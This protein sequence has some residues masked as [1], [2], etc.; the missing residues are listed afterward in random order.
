M[1]I[2]LTEVLDGSGAIVASG[3]TFAT[4]AYADARFEGRANVATW[5]AASDDTQKRAMLD[6][7]ELLQGKQWIGRLFIDTQPKDWPRVG[8]TPKERQSRSRIRTGYE[9]LTGASAGIYDNSGKFWP[10]TSIP[11]PI[12]DAQCDLAFLFVTDDFRKQDQYSSIVTKAGSTTLT[13]KTGADL[14]T[15][16][17]P[18]TIAAMLRPFLLAAM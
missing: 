4:I 2:T 10:S 15:G 18:K 5:D 14:L 16:G 13:R 7:M 6:A 8:S 1:A 17:I 11:A 9:T 12:K 3:N